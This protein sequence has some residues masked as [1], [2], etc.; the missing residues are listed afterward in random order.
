MKEL[1]I[2]FS[3]IHENYFQGEIKDIKEGNTA[4]VAKKIQEYLGA[5]IFEI[6]ELDPY[7]QDYDACTKRA[8]DEKLA[9]S[10]PKY[11]KTLKSL[12]KYDHI[13]LG[14][15]I[16]WATMPMVVWSFLED[17]TFQNKTIHPFITHEGSEIGE[18]VKD[19]ELL[20]K[21]ATIASALVIR[22]SEVDGS[23]NKIKKWLG[24]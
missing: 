15:P 6:K 1:V 4:K 8:T 24:K 7:P 19:L 22:G 16:W 13:Y 10:R 14:Y 20:V 17:N 11:Q 9:N 2:Y 23:D 3:H 12:D 5:D 21:G 18:S